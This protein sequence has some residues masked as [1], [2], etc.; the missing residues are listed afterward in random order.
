MTLDLLIKM[1]VSRT[2]IFTLTQNI[3]IISI[4][5]DLWFSIRKLFRINNSTWF[6]PYISLS[7][8]SFPNDYLLIHHIISKC[9]ST[10]LSNC[11]PHPATYSS[12]TQNKQSFRA[13]P[14]I[15]LTISRQDNAKFGDK[16]TQ[17]NT[18]HYK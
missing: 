6:P 9:K 17:N 18:K 10:K 1:D 11:F 4:K 14:H 12:A 3:L 15:L 7:L 8:I 13:R 16:L 2:S 5:D